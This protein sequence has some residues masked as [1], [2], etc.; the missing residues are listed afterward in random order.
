MKFVTESIEE[1]F[2][3]SCSLFIKDLNLST[4]PTQHSSDWLPY[5]SSSIDIF[6]QSIDTSTSSSASL[7]QY[8]YLLSSLLDATKHI[9]GISSML[10]SKIL[11]LFHEFPEE[12]P[13]SQ[14]HKSDFH[15]LQ[16][17]QLCDY[18]FPLILR[19]LKHEIHQHVFHLIHT[20]YTLPNFLSQIH[21]WISSHL[22]PFC[23]QIFS[24]PS[25][26]SRSPH[27]LTHLSEDLIQYSYHA[28][29]Q[30][31]S[32]ELFDII[33][34]YPDSTPAI[35]E[36]KECCLRVPSSL[37][38]LGKDLKQ[39]LS[40]RLLHIGASTSQIIDFY[41]SLIRSLRLL[42]PS[43]LLL[44]HVAISI[45]KYLI[46]RTD[47][48]RCVISLL[49]EKKDDF[50][51]EFHDGG[52]LE[53]G[54]DS[55]D[56]TAQVITAQTC[57]DWSPPLRIHDFTQF[58]QSSSQSDKDIL[59]ILVSIYGTTDLFV[60]EYR[61]ILADRLLGNLD[62]DIDNE[63]ATLELLKLRF[64]EESLH[65]CEVMLH[66]LETS[67]RINHAIQKEISSNGIDCTIISDSY[68]PSLQSDPFTHHPAPAQLLQSFIDSF[69][70]V[71]KPKLFS[72]LPQ[73][74]LLP[75]PPPPLLTLLP[76]LC[77]ASDG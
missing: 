55:D 59:S 68:W 23:Q 51:N 16:K 74:G 6:F 67:K 37:V 47:T 7:S 49:T 5:L 32:K 28:L 1:Y 17:L 71:K 72:L 24:L 42:D 73:L 11:H 22:L 36:L 63:V 58:G 19:L 53:Y 25:Q 21:Q 44:N 20:D 76:P 60:S 65:S 56:E 54:L 40:K 26:S 75:Y 27:P 50:Q 52:L 43:N 13:L 8:Q 10:S 57:D 61:S 46:N 2:F 41:I 3:R 14:S 39:V 62:Y 30:I 9:P 33:I 31:R 45:R 77:R 69:A 70:I 4:L 18:Y 48:I 15:L 35:A 29:L 64:G 12:D 66:D 34:N 38:L